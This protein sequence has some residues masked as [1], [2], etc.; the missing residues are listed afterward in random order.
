MSRAVIADQVIQLRP[1]SPE[2]AE[3]HL[4]GCDPVTV[5]SL[6]GGEPPNRSHVQLWLTK[7]AST[8][9]EGEQVLVLGIEDTAT[10]TLFGIV[11][12]QRGLDYLQ[13]G[14]VNLTYALYPNWRGRGYATRAVRLA[15]EV[16]RR[17]APVREFV[18]RAAAW[19][20]T[21][22]RVAQRL[23]FQHS[24]TTDDAN[25]RLE[26]FTDADSPTSGGNNEA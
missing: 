7:S 26:W 21:S 18:I 19:N 9:A 16:A 6:G 8:W 20:G 4:L 3:T 5:E 15:T 2:D 10:G 23:G 13:P 24:R 12:I 25:G 1:L 14:Q 22:I 17:A 11:G